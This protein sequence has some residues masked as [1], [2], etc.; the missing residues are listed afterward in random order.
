LHKDGAQQNSPTPTSTTDSIEQ[1]LLR[2][3]VEMSESAFPHSPLSSP[4]PSPLPSPLSSLV[5]LSSQSAVLVTAFVSSEDSATVSSANLDPPA[6][7]SAPATSTTGVSNVE[8]CVNS[9]Q[10]AGGTVGLQTAA[11]STSPAAKPSTATTTARKII[12]V[13]RQLLHHPPP[14]P[15]PA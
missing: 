11:L 2:G 14:P 7:N 1:Q 15:A 6:T 10:P 4:S 12:V 3:T 8:K 13:P 9:H 5:S